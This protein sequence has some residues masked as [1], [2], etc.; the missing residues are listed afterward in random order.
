MT[1]AYRGAAVH[2]TPDSLAP[3]N[4]LP[5]QYGD[6]FRCRDCGSVQ[7]PALPRGAALLELYRGMRD[8]A[9]LEQETGRRRTARRLLSLL[10][11][12]PFGGR[13]L[14]VG[15][16]HGLLLDEARRRGWSV[17]GLDVS[18]SA[19]AYA[20]TRLGLPVDEI[21][22]EDSSL[23]G[24]AFDAVVL[25][26]VLEHLD[27]PAGS[28]RRCQQLLAPGGALLVVTPDPAS[29]TARLAGGRWWAYLPAHTCL[30]PRAV[31]R[32]LM[33][34]HDLVLT[35]DGPLVRS[36]TLSYWLRGLLE[37][38]GQLGPGPQAVLRRLPADPIVSL[39]LGDERVVIARAIAVRRPER[40]A[41]HASRSSAHVPA[42][43]RAER[44]ATAGGGPPPGVVAPRGR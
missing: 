31:L 22:V 29:L 1:L 2:D 8:D 26:D 35:H 36:F 16:G 11:D 15:C 25:V 18:A 34:A 40:A 23:D 38:G 4:H 27:D 44:A 5:S 9:Y 32:E 12:R 6:L 21:P 14:E 24:S 3:T 43:R 28:L 20:R 30:I 19:A 42:E 39:S 13:L 17:R 10:S 7:Q 33:T 37:R 41:G